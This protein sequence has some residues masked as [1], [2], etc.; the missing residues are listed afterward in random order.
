MV[1]LI[2]AAVSGR[3]AWACQTSAV[4]GTRADR[5]ASDQA[6]P[7]PVTRVIF[8]TPQTGPPAEMKAST[9]SL[10]DLVLTAGEVIVPARLAW[11]AEVIRSVAGEDGAGVAEEV[12]S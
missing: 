4:P 5:T 12:S 8:W 7:P 2:V 1:A 9:S 11:P 6:R 3:A 10:P